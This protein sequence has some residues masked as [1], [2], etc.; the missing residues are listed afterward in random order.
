MKLPAALYP[1]GEA[2]CVRRLSI[3]FRT[4]PRPVSVFEMQPDDILERALRGEED[5]YCAQV[6]PSS[7]AASEALLRYLPTHS[8]CTVMELGCGPGLPSLSALAAGASSVTA[9]DWSPL[10]LALTTHAANTFQPSRVSRLRTSR[11]NLLDEYDRESYA[12][13]LLVAADLLYDEAVAHAVGKHVSQHLQHGGHAI[14]ADPGRP[15]GRAAFS[16]GLHSCSATRGMVHHFVEQA[17]PKR[18][19]GSSSNATVGICTL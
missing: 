1:H 19:S 13:D 6:W 16:S 17:L 18:W 11:L 2:V 15:G 4:L 8:N 9:T 7:Y 14:I 12:A 10:A 5:E 3:H